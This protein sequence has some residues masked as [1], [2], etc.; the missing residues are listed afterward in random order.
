[1]PN[2]KQKLISFISQI[3]SAI[4]NKKPLILSFVLVFILELLI[5][6]A[7]LPVRFKDFQFIIACYLVFSLT[8]QAV[9]EL[10]EKNPFK[11]LLSFLLTLV[12]GLFFIRSGL[13]KKTSIALSTLLTLISFPFLLVF[14]FISTKFLLWAL[15]EIKRYLFLFHDNFTGVILKIRIKKLFKFGL[16]LIL[17][18]FILS[19]GYFIGHKRGE[20]YGADRYTGRVWQSNEMQ[21]SANEVLEKINNYRK[22]RGLKPFQETIG[23]CKLAQ[24]RVKEGA[25]NFISKWNFT[26]NRFEGVNPHDIHDTKLSQEEMQ[27]LCPECDLETLGENA[28]GSMSPGLCYEL[29]SNKP[30]GENGIFGIAMEDHTGNVVNGWIDSMGHHKLLM[31][32]IETG[33]VASYGGFVMLVVAQVK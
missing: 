24:A 17:S 12:L 10:K 25:L 14:A 9:D 31:S 8:W 3:P 28:F 22:S 30:C 27:A 19:A 15:K 6:T 11:F 32:S 13:F 1:M 2:Y 26:T 16:I 33:C 29:G 4:F 21:I 5:Q 18:F 23:I 20:Q 7:F